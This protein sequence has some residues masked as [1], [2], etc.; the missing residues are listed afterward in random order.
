MSLMPETLTV[1]RGDQSRFSCRTTRPQ[2]GAMIWQLSGKTMLTISQQ[3][4]LVPSTNP[5]ITAEK[6][7]PSQGEGWTLVLKDTQ[8][9]YQGEV[10]CDLQEVHKRTA[11]LYVQGQCIRRR[12]EWLNVQDYSLI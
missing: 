3:N 2:W 6:A 12:S 11:H 9:E 10:S 1:L 8:R 7:A 4:G 5:N